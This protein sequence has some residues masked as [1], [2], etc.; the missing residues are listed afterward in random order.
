[1]GKKVQKE[2]SDKD[3][4]D[5]AIWLS[6]S[7]AQNI[8]Y[9]GPLLAHPQYGPLADVRYTKTSFV[10]VPSKEPVPTMPE[11]FT[12][13]DILQYLAT[14]TSLL[15]FFSTATGALQ[16]S[17][18]L[19]VKN[20]GKVGSSLD[21]VDDVAQRAMAEVS[22]NFGRYCSYVSIGITAIQVSMEGMNENTGT[23]VIICAIGFVPG[24]GWVISGVYTIANAVVTVTTKKTIPETVKD[25]LFEVW[26]N[27][28]RELENRVR[29]WV[30]MPYRF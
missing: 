30:Q 29:H 16:E 7:M 13:Q 5:S 20:G 1:M 15:S 10:L 23:D 25:S 4:R 19:A 11:R 14:T 3:I 8:P 9:S 24:V 2:L 21:L 6:L 18:I 27:F 28:N 26:Y 12:L 22:K 17:D